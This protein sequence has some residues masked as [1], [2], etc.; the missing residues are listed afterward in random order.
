MIKKKKDGRWINKF[1][2]KL[3]YWV[4]KVCSIIFEEIARFFEILYE[5]FLFL[6]RCL[7]VIFE[8]LE[9]IVDVFRIF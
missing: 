6:I 3:S 5:I 1:I 7:G 4:G 9:D 8:I 2:K